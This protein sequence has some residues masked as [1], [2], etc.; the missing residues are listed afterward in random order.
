MTITVDDIR[1]LCQDSDPVNPIIGDDAY[2][3]I[4][5]YETNIWRAAAMGCRAIAAK[6]SKK[7]E[8]KAGPVTLKGAQAAENYLN[9][10]KSFD[11]RA[12]S[13]AGDILSGGSA[14]G[15]VVPGCSN[16][17]FTLGGMDG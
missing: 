4:V 3:I 12:A 17:I 2:T 11:I 15:P 13:G 5:Q 9:L 16:R 7:T 10:A 6:L 14:G 8:I 1:A